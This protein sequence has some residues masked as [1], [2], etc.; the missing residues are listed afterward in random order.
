MKSLQIRYIQLLHFYKY[1]VELHTTVKIINIVLQDAEKILK[2][3]RG[4][5]GVALRHLFPEVGLEL[6][7][8]PK[9]CMFLSFF[10]SVFLSFVV[11]ILIVGNSGLLEV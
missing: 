9:A 2:Y 3:Y 4:N 1:I 6:S 5:I 8:V 10:L 11:I 7:K